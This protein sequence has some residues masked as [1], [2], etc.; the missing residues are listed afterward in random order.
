MLLCSF[1]FVNR[2]LKLEKLFSASIALIFLMIFDEARKYYDTNLHSLGNL[3]A[4]YCIH[5]S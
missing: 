3:D 4:H 5:T 1:I 2:C